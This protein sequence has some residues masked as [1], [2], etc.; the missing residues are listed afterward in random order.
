VSC[1]TTSDKRDL[2][3][4]V[5]TANGVEVDPGGKKP[6]RG[7]YVCRNPAC[8]QQALRKGRL[9]AALRTALS[10]DEKLKLAEFAASLQ[11]VA[12]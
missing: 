12:V 10:A 5:R 6:G 8:W 4:V 3:R 11:T 1:R 2:V 7:A 9:D